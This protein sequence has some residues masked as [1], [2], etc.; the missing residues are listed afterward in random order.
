MFHTTYRPEQVHPSVFIAKEAVIVGDVTLA[1]DCSV[2]YHASLRADTEAIIIGPRTNIQEGAIFH[3]DP[4]YAVELGAGVTIGHGAIIHG[5]KVGDNSL[6]GM[7]ATVLDGAVIGENSLVGAQALVTAG[8]V[9]PPGS[10]ILGM[11]AKVIRPLT[12]EEIESNRRSAEQYVKR[13]QA[14]KQG[15]K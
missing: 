13:A 14:F 4:G 9:F 12:P 8:K 6:V 10:L 3:V 7:Q 2:W 11:P 1:E 15:Q 5:A